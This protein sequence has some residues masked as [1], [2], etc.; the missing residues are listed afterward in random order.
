[1]IFLRKY[2][3]LTALL[4]IAISS[5]ACASAQASA[6]TAQTEPTSQEI[7][8]SFS[9]SKLPFGQRNI[10]AQVWDSATGGTLIFSEAHSNVKVGWVGEFDFVLGSQTQNGI[11]PSAFPSGTS[12]Y[13]DVLDQNNHSVLATR[14]PLYA[15][16]FAI[17]SGTQGP[18]GPAG[19]QGPVGPQGPQGP[20]GLQGA[21]GAPG[22][23]GPAGPPGSTGA[24][25]QAG[26][27]VTFRNAWSSTATYRIGDAVSENGTSYIALTANV[28]VDPTTDVVGN[29]GN[30]AVL[31]QAGTNGT[32]ATVAIGTTTTVAA[33]TP[34]SVNNSGSNNAA[35]LNFVIP[36]G[37]QGIPGP[38][39]TTG[40]T[41][42]TGPTGVQGPTGP[43]GLTG[44]EGPPV[45]FKGPW[46]SSTIYSTGDAVSE[47][48]TS[49][50]AR[51][52]N[53]N[54][55]P[56]ND[57]A[58]G[59]PN[60]AVLAQGETFRGPWGAT[61][62]YYPGDVVSFNG[63]SYV[64]LLNNGN[65]Q[66]DL[67]IGIV[68]SLL[69]AA[70]TNGTPATVSVGTTT[71]GAPGTAASV[72]NIGTSSAAL[73]NFT[74]P[75]GLP[76]LPGAPGLQGPP[77]PSGVALATPWDSAISYTAGS[78]VIYN[79]AFFV[80]LSGN[81]GTTPGSSA[82]I[83]IWSGASIGAGSS[84]AGIPYTT[85]I[86]VLTLSTG[87]DGFASP[88]SY[89]AA[90][91]SGVPSLGAADTVMAPVACTPSMTIYN[92]SILNG[93]IF[94]YHLT[95]VQ[96]NLASSIGWSSVS[97]VASCSI[98]SATGTGSACTAT[99]SSQV[100]AGTILT[101][102]VHTADPTFPNPNVFYSA[103]SCY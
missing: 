43:T 89:G 81:S 11:P 22:V 45:S 39:G 52:T 76:G 56:A 63:S 60:W 97:N 1:M 33:G 79:G 68:W 96:P 64:A 5:A 86:H 48:G 100:A 99:A 53:L 21:Q 2:L 23:Q 55:D 4:A 91:T 58:G 38:M 35:V 80:A 92:Y 31:A 49:Y 34:A 50:I 102:S 67:T 41:G 25:G 72:T 29:G 78:L 3:V 103:F 16:S 19:A 51:T 15:A 37:P 73:L 30:W 24:T 66:P 26:P 71:T 20:M 75:Q 10:S 54:V 9:A 93:D 88:T 28:N 69:A 47:N 94:T 74:I 62:I 46:S 18:A 27:P 59:G 98:F 61:N 44:P 85:G 101:L 84:P 90:G 17:M 36:Q 83:G 70:G 82:A 77:G 87:G 12:R 13:L 8:F 57:V 14:K 95:T 65:N 7:E 32:A 40:A 6:G 42:P